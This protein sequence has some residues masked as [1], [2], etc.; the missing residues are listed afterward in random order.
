MTDQTKGRRIKNL[1]SKYYII[2]NNTLQTEPLWSVM[3][4]SQR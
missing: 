4:H 1:K 3:K 2:P